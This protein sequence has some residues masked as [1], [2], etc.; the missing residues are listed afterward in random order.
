M[1]FETVCTDIEIIL[2]SEVSHTSTSYA[3]CYMW[4]LKKGHNELCRT[5]IDSQTLT[6]RRWKTYGFQMR[7]VPGW[8]MDC[9]FGMERL[10]N[11]VV[12]IVEKL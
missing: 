7:H 4:N 12:M 11:G 6:H 8:G 1:A 3:I 10:Y 5:D 9:G 2:L